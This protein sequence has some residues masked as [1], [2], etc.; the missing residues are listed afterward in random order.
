MDISAQELQD[1]FDHFD[2]DNDGRI[3][4]PA[5]TCLMQALDATASGGELSFGFQAI[6]TNGGGQVEFNE[7]SDWFASH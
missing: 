6:A 5:F 2:T 3:D 1:N 7:F 4:L